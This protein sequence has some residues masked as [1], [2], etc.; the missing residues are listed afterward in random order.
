MGGLLLDLQ[1]EKLDDES[2]LQICRQSGRFNDLVNRLLQL[3]R[4]KRRSVKPRRLMTT[5]CRPWLTYSSSVVTA[6]WLNGWFMLE[7]IAASD[8]RLSVW[9]KDYA[10][11]QGDF[12]KA[13]E[14]AKPLFLSRPSTAEYLR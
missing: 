2:F 8:F 3:G 1:A 6:L 12:P 5:T 9:L 14:W 13:L 7:Q 10:S 4:W 11:L